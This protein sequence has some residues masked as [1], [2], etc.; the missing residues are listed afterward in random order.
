MLS[1][2]IYVPF[3][4][5]L[6]DKKRTLAIFINKYGLLNYL[7]IRLYFLQ[8]LLYEVNEDKSVLVLELTLNNF[9]SKTKLLG[10]PVKSAYSVFCIF[11]QSGRRHHDQNVKILIKQLWPFFCD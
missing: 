8:I 9:F 10:D 7:V 11:G 2:T 5:T 4:F 1:P 3:C 6:N